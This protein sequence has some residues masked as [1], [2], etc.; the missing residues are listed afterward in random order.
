MNMSLNLLMFPENTVGQ[1]RW[2]LELSCLRYT[3]CLM[4]M[5]MNV[6]LCLYYYFVNRQSNSLEPNTAY[7][8][9]VTLKIILYQ[10]NLCA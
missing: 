6:I 3:I 2:L 5:F 8:L 9:G 10:N 7:L 4:F 1:F